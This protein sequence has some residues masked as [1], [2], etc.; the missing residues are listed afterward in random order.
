[1]WTGGG[2]VVGVAACWRVLVGLEP[3]GDS[4]V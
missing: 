2:L 1:M 3:F 4:I